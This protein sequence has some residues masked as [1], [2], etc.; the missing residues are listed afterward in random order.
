MR[1]IGRVVLKESYQ[2]DYIMMSRCPCQALS[3]LT[4]ALSEGY[5]RTNRG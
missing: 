1:V 4:E 2:V 5:N 3:E